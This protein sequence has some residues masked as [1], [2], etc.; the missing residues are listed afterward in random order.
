MNDPID[1]RRI[2][3]LLVEDN[4]GDVALV[5]LALDAAGLN[6]DATVID[7][8]ADALA[9]VDG[10]DTPTPDLVILDLNIPRRDGLE[11]LEA[12]RSVSAFAAV[13]VVILTSSSSPR[14]REKLEAFGIY[15][16]ITK[17]TDFDEFMSIGLILK[18][19]LTES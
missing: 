1:A 19:I 2:R 9:Y 13:P 4:P 17:P 14:E 12:L 18:D 3:I 6:Y 7:D 11:V 5:R 8:G 15:R 10:Q 16:Y